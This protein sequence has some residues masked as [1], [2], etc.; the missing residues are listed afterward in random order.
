MPRIILRKLHITNFGPI[1]NDVVDLESYTF[2]VGRNNAGKSH[3][4]RA[5]E[6]LL[7]TRKPNR[8]ELI[9]LQ[10]DKTREITIKGEFTGVRE[11][12][13]LV[14]A[15][16]HRQSIESA[17]DN[18]DVLTVVRTFN[19]NDEDDTIF[20]IQKLDGSIHNPTGFSA[21]L[22]KVLPETISIVATAD[23]EDELRNKDNT[24]LSRIKK[25]VLRSFLDE[26]RLKTRDAVLVLDQ[27][28]NDRTSGTRS[29]RLVQFEGYLR[30]ELTG[31]FSSVIPSVE[32]ELPDEEVIAKEMKIYLDDGH[33]SEIEQKGHGLQRAA[34]LA[35]LRVL[36]K[37]GSRYLDRPSPIFLIGELETFL[38][39]YAQMLLANTLCNLVDQY[40]IMTSTHSPF[41]VSPE[42]IDGYR[43]VRKDSQNATK[44]TVFNGSTI[45]AETIRRHLNRR[46]NLEGLFADRIVL[47]E[48]KHDEPFFEKIRKVFGIEFPNNKLTL[49]I[50]CDGK[51]ELR[52]VR[53]FYKSMGFDDVAIISDLDYLF[54]GDF[55]K[56]AEDCGILNW[57]HTNALRSYIGWTQE[58]T[59]SLETVLRELATRG[60]PANFELVLSTLK[61]HRLFTLKRGSP[62]MYYKNA[63]GNKEGWSTVN[64][65]E[66]LYDPD[67][68][69]HLM[70]NL[71]VSIDS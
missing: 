56:L 36:A 24:A 63:L 19:P 59:P 70:N 53:K 14:T 32:F 40:Q 4:L 18:N 47:I 16:N 45:N 12:T 27:F 22:L 30:A 3:Y 64:S 44:S 42:T 29:P 43:R 41:I 26:L 28:L 33:K 48:G 57:E 2:F 69:S 31:E 50:K 67:E 6:V 9:R 8:E 62:E 71:F 5:V 21:N 17:I 25:E 34:L 11:Y 7:S 55:N 20:G 51:E 15:S 39:P 38:H 1:E 46:G 52:Q 61:Q 65:Q 10:N 54:S 58:G 37:H 23:T 68:L 13:S 66:D 35:L 60:T 49:F